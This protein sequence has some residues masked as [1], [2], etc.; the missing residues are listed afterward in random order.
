MKVREQLGEGL[1]TF[2]TGHGKGRTGQSTESVCELPFRH[3][4]QGQKEAASRSSDGPLG[5]HLYTQQDSD[6]AGGADQGGGVAGS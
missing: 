2:Q 1:D 5:H 4:G 3:F 6:E